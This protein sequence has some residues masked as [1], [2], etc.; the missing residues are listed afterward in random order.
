MNLPNKLTILR[1]LL[2]PL[3]I[4]F[5]LTQS[6]PHN[7][8]WALIVFSAASLT[9]FFDGMLARKHGLVSDF[10][11]LMDPLADKI[12]VASALI[13]FVELGAIPCVVTI[14]VIFREF[15]VTSFRL[16]AVEK[17]TV[18][19][20]DIW[21]KAKTV[22]QIFAIIWLLLCFE[23]NTLGLIPAAFPLE[24]ISSVIMWI[25]AAL[26]VLSGANYIISNRKL[27]ENM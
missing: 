22:F 11:K 6:V 9:D 20:A 13:C 5:M 4:F 26:T 12:L 2:V 1:V 3:L 19:A 23:C 10:G 15:L 27:I 7:Y 14:I 21:G 24:T 25:M 16:I 8:L 17:G 18:I